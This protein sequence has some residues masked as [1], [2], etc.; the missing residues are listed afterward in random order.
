MDRNIRN[1][2]AVLMQSPHTSAEVK[3]SAA[4]PYIH[5]YVRFYQTRNCLLIAE[6]ITDLPHSHSICQHPVFRFHICDDN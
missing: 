6:K 5:G 2:F 1:Y 3:D 4:Y